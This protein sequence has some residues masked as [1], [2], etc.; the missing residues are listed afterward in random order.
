MIVNLDILEQRFIEFSQFVETND[1]KAFE[2][3]ETCIYFDKEKY[4]EVIYNEARITINSAQLKFKDIGTGRIHKTICDA[5]KKKVVYK[6]E[7]HDNNLINW[8]KKDL[9]SK[10][11]N[12]NNLEVILF[13]LYTSKVP[14]Q[15][16]FERLLQ[17]KL[18][19]QL[20]AYL[21][22]IKESKKYMPIAQ[23]KFDNVFKL[24]G[25]GDFKTSHNISWDNYSNFIDIIK[26]SYLYFSFFHFFI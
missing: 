20:I 25:L 17:E 2:S 22:F 21:F 1:N 6:N 11:D 5:I 14:D 9:F 15:I 16:S 3:F 7:D 13:E 8:R 26:Q 4:K 23:E 10:L 18:S 24:I 19:Y 12:P